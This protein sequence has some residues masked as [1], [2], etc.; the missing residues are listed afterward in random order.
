MGAVGSTET[1]HRNTD[2]SLTVEVEFVESLHGDEQSQRGVKSATDTDH[3]LLGIDM[4]E[5]FGET[6]HLDIQDLLA[7]C[8]HILV[9]GNKRM[10]IDL[11]LE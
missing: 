8:L 10:G 1:W 4:I 3:G 11:T 6:C 9:L 2:D 5:S 7:G